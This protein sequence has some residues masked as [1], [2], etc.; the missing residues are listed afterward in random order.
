MVISKEPISLNKC[1]LVVWHGPIVN[2]FYLNNF[3]II[4]IVLFS[5]EIWD[6]KI[7]MNCIDNMNFIDDIW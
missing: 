7:I 6:I 3:G 5:L 2:P 1:H 4:Q